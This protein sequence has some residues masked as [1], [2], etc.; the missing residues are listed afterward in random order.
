MVLQRVRVADDQPMAIE[1]SHVVAS[2]CPGILDRYDF[3][4][5]SLYRV[6]RQ[7]YG[8]A[9]AHAEQSIAARGATPTGLPMW[10]HRTKPYGALRVQ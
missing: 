7:E 6:L 3:E 9:L 1:T 4:Q 8:L 5:E 10:R 2:A